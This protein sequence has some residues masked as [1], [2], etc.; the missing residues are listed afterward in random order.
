MPL[1]RATSPIGIE[2][3]RRAG[4]GLDPLGGMAQPGDFDASGVMGRVSPVLTDTL[5]EPRV[6]KDDSAA[7]IAIARPLRSGDLSYHVQAV[8]FPIG[9]AV[10]EWHEVTAAGR[11]LDVVF[12]DAPY[13]FVIPGD[14]L[15]ASPSDRLPVREGGCVQLLDPVQTWWVWTPGATLALAPAPT[16]RAIVVVHNGEL[17]LNADNYVRPTQ[18]LLASSVAVSGAVR[19]LALAHPR[20]LA[21]TFTLTG[22]DGSDSVSIGPPAIAFGDGLI[23]QDTHRGPHR[24]VRGAAAAFFRGISV[25]VGSTIGILEEF[26]EPVE[27]PTIP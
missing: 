19:D 27:F 13:L 26:R 21:I 25:G 10:G 15:R 23:L 4:P 12:S 2:A 11:R 5:A 7:D 20:R 16:E 9:L 17:C 24:I 8:E 18:T 3:L 1:R 14:V 6:I 22:P